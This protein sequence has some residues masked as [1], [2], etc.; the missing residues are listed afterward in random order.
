MIKHELVVRVLCEI[1]TPTRV[2]N[3]TYIYKITLTEQRRFY[4]DG[5]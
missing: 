5:Y 3:S 1:N 4:E 2:L